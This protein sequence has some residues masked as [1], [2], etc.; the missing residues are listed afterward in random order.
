MSALARYFKHQG[1]AV[2]GYDRTPSDLTR[3]LENEGIAIIYNDSIEDLRLK[4]ED[5]SALH[6]L[7]VRT[8][9]VPEDSVVY[10]YLREEGFDSGPCSHGGAASPDRPGSQ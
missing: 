3:E 10:T 6:T 4:I 8:P 1:Y 9:A 2:S 7:V 5:L